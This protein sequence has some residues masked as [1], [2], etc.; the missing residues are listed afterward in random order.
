LLDTKE[1]EELIFW[2]SKTSDRE[3]YITVIRML[4]IFQK[5]K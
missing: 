2:F 3:P 5:E 4:Y 1:S